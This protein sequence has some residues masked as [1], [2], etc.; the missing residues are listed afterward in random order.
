[1]AKKKKSA[2]K[3]VANRGF[4]TTSTPSKRP[5]EPRITHIGAASVNE[6]GNGDESGGENNKAVQFEDFDTLQDGLRKNDDEETFDPK[7]EED[8]ALQNVVDRLRDRVEKDVLRYWRAIEF[9]RRQARQLP[10][11][12][13]DSKLQEAILSA[14]LDG[15]EDA[16]EFDHTQSISELLA[17]VGPSAAAS[18]LL[19]KAMVTHALLVRLGFT[20]RQAISALSSCQSVTDVDECVAWLSFRL[21]SEELEIAD[22]R[23]DGRESK[24]TE[25]Q[26]EDRG[27]D[28]DDEL[29]VDESRPPLHPAYTFER[30]PASSHQ[31]SLTPYNGTSGMN[32]PS[33][34]GTSGATTPFELSPVAVHAIEESKL[35][36]SH[37]L[38]HLDDRHLVDTLESPVTAYA[39]ARLA[40]IKVEKSSGSLEKLCKGYSD[41]TSALLAEAR[42]KFGQVRAKTRGIISECLV[43]PKWNDAAGEAEF[44]TLRSHWE[45]DE[46]QKAAQLLEDT[47]PAVKEEPMAGMDE[48]MDT[49][50]GMASATLQSDEDYDDAGD[51]AG[52]FGDLLDE[53]AG[54]ITDAATQTIVKLRE[55]PTQALKSQG[56]KAP[57]NLLLECLRRREP[58]ASIRF[59]VVSTGGKMF[60]SRLTMR[61]LKG[62]V[63]EYTMTGMATLSQNSADDLLALAALLCVDPKADKT[64][65]SGFRE[66]WAELMELRQEERNAVS[67]QQFSRILSALGNRLE[68]AN[69]QAEET[70]RLMK[71]SA[72]Q[73]SARVDHA[74]DSAST[75][76]ES[77]HDASLL[78]TRGQEMWEKRESSRDYKMMLP[79]R[80]GLPIAAFKAHIIDTLDNNQVTVLSGETGCGKSTQLPAYIVESKLSQGI[81][82]KVLVTEP[83]RISAISLA[84]RVSA[85]LGEPRHSVGKG[86]SLVGSAVRLEN[87]IGRNARLIYATT[88]I[89]LRMLED[90]DL[91]GITHI[92]VDEV[93]ERSIESDFLLIILKQLM[94]V[95]KDLKVVLMSATLDAERFS[96]YFGGCPTLHV[97]GRT[98][99]VEVCWLED[100]VE[101]CN[102]V[103]EDGS[104]YARRRNHRNF[105]MSNKARL[106]VAKT[107]GEDDEQFNDG[108]EE[109][110]R[111]NSA[112]LKGGRYRAKT[113]ST[114]DR[115]D[116]Y[117]VNHELIISLLEHMC[118]GPDHLQAYSAATLVFLPGIADIRRLNDMLLSHKKFGTQAFQ[119]WP[120]HSTITSE[121][122]SLVFDI[123]PKGVRKIVLS[124]NIAETGITIPD[125]TC[126]ID[127]GKHREMRFDEKRQ[128]SKL[129]ECFVARSNAKQRRGR[130]G[131]VQNGMCWHLFTRHRHDQLLAEHSIPEI[132]RLSLQDLALK[133]KVMKIRIGNSI[134]DALSK[135]LDAPSSINIQRAVASLVEVKALL[136][137]EDI[138]PLGKQ[139]SRL[140]LD[141][142]MAKF[143]LNACSLR[144]LD[145][146]LTIAATLNAKSP[147]LTPFGRELEARAVK[148]S[149]DAGDNDFVA[150]VRVFNAWRRATENG[151]GKQFCQKCFLSLTNLIQI[152]ELRQQYLTYLVDA[153]FVPV[154]EVARKEIVGAHFRFSHG[155]SKS[156]FVRV[157][158]A[159]N[160]YS[161]SLAQVN[162]TIIS[163]LYPKLLVVD[164]RNGALKTLTNNAPASIH[165]SSVNFKLRLDSLP[166]SIHHLVYFTIMQSR[167]LYAWETAAVEER[168]VLLLCGEAD[169][170]FSS[171]SLYIDRQRI[172]VTFYDRKMQYALR[173]I[174]QRLGRLL[175]TSYRS[176]GRGW[177]ENDERMFE[178]VCQ[179]LGVN[180]NEKDKVVV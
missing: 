12:E 169:F 56:S 73:G 137:N 101:A 136:S 123:P 39:N 138:T 98:F 61:W 52:L 100:A 94:A 148:K 114:L 9:D 30:T 37:L 23:C 49:A 173:A 115:M 63:D 89:V 155:G 24:L 174:R 40:S 131:R 1:M 132:L 95:K 46:A 48:I 36:C 147:F 125:I 134:E 78:D 41:S 16:I 118:F 11:M 171:T 168:A 162:A 57:R 156:R 10:I 90:G 119:V 43:S 14:T 92:I 150:I 32:T 22:R 13:V 85:E 65:G 179:F 3:P 130:A 47:G 144:V 127:S 18:E 38:Q 96:E 60:R 104:Q 126:V 160:V 67:R 5:V 176:P 19:H 135:A 82:C 159:L 54:E 83:R 151:V 145:S 158:D 117:A 149:F 105:D 76:G 97:P 79:I 6:H 124:T 33:T 121:N 66:W 62:Q 128:L 120:L 71:L 44:R 91:E 109:E 84:E 25:K 161:S 93:H 108:E 53:Q 29:I 28:D 64:L 177:E 34:S 74:Q 7:S 15:Q 58:S 172:R 143:L 154:D 106:A 31:G 129:V 4:A 55:L 72:Q 133:L 20:S 110:D 27:E 164:S 116:E 26:S 180:A 163:A 107:D 2:L 68:Q 111:Q 50:N 112:S 122:Q 70:K 21:T 86:D 165:P 153:G 81:H 157:P 146:A 175:N 51:G 35:L 178:L 77:W 142:Y 17:H 113:V 139:L 141:V 140:P 170:K 59:E 42:R 103:L 80:E 45:D 75:N 8:Q 69:R 167:R 166:R 88:G 87:N 152:E 102:Y 99:P